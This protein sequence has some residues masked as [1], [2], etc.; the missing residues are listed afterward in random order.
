MT[1]EDLCKL[2]KIKAEI[3]QIKAELS[4]VEL[5]YVTDSVKASS[6]NFPYT[7]YNAKIS[8]YDYEAYY[9]KVHRIQN[10]LNRKLDELMDEK[11]KLL[12]YIHSIDDSELRQILTYVYVDG[13]KSAEVGDHMG[14]S[15]R[16]IERKL[17]KWHERNTQS[18]VDCR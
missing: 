10:R 2:K 5:D 12:E 15:S 14:C 17:K 3:E 16:T 6:T 1:K 13:L 8:G 11:D 18:V 7:Q 9:R 4:S